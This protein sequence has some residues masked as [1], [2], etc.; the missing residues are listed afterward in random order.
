[1]LPQASRSS[2]RSWSRGFAIAKDEY[3]LIDPEE[4]DALKVESSKIIDIERFVELQAIDRLYWDE[5]YYLVPDGKTAI[6]AFA[7]I[8]DAMREK[9]RVG[10]WAASCLSQRERIVALEPRNDIILLTTL[11]AHDEVRGPPTIS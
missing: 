9:D 6:E 10:P 5:P 2:A 1:M 7:V 3:V 11:R 8:R 4:I